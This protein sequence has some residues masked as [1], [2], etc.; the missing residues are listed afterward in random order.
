MNFHRLILISGATFAAV[1]VSATEPG[2]YYSSCEG[3][4]GKALLQQLQTVIDDHTVVGYKNLY[5]VY[6]D[7][8][9]HPDGTI[10]DMYSTKE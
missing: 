5:D 10:W 1:A 3:K 7:S 9:R 4:T 8:D 2:G 6:D